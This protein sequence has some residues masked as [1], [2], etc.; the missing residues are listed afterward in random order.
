[1]PNEYMTQ[2]VHSP[3]T[4]IPS[5]GLHLS[6]RLSM[7]HRLFIEALMFHS[8]T[9]KVRICVNSEYRFYTQFML[10]HCPFHVSAVSFKQ[11]LWCVGNIDWM[12]VDI[13][14]SVLSIFSLPLR[15]YTEWSPSSDA[16]SRSFVY[17]ILRLLSK[18]QSRKTIVFWDVMLYNVS[19]RSKRSSILQI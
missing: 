8:T 14:L 13:H 9:V 17:N 10:S 18:A 15:N 3:W 12:S 5:T 2:F 6:I 16:D 4:M 1:M 7:K 11:T 19:D